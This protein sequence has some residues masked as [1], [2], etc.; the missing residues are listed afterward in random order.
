M[1]EPAIGGENAGFK[2]AN[3]GMGLIDGTPGTPF[4]LANSNN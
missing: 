2:F 1:S 4:H 3:E